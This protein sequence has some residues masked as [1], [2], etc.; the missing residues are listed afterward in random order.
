[1]TDFRG[2]WTEDEVEEFLQEATIPVRIATR[3]PD[4]SPWVVTLWFR[5]RDGSLECATGAN[6]DVVRFLRRDPEVAFDISTNDI[7]YRGIRGTEPSNSHPIAKRRSCGPSSSDISV[8][9]SPRSHSDCSTT[10]A[11]RFA[12]D[13]S[14]ERSTA[15][16]IANGWGKARA[17]NPNN[18]R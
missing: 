3:R 6:A 7:P 16:T 2:T 14:R 9:Q 13:S 10:T 11:T 18:V 1:M 8:G 17:K 15:G 5:Y 12:S 4:D